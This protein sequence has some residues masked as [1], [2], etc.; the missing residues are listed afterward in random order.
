MP[1]CVFHVDK[2]SYGIG[3]YIWIY[4]R[5]IIL[6][7]CNSAIFPLVVISTYREPLRGWIDNLYG[8]TGVAAGAGSGLLRSIHCDGS[9]HA[10]VV[11]A[12]MTINALIACAWDVQNSHRYLLSWSAR[13][14]FASNGALRVS[15][16]TYHHC[17]DLIETRR[18]T[19]GK[20]ADGTDVWRHRW[21]RNP[22]EL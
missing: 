7:E 8:P 17:R 20:N 1:H 9:M 11:P 14:L 5:S 15:R 10:N 4:N 22:F 6:L 19:T 21:P 13:F 16:V 12:D 2:K 18:R 3:N